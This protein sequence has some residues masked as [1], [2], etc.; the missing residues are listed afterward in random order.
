MP[1]KSASEHDAKITEPR[2]VDRKR[3]VSV[4]V[5]CGIM[6]LAIDAWLYL[7]LIPWIDSQEWARTQYGS[8]GYAVFFIMTLFTFLASL[9]LAAYYFSRSS[10]P[11]DKWR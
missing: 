2:R 5:V 11:S 6:V 9:A 3:R 4:V 10:Y 8:V 1:R 7:W